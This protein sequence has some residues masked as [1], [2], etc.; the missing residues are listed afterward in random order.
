LKPAKETLPEPERLVTPA[1]L[2]QEPEQEATLRPSRLDDYVG[3]GKVVSALRIFIQAAK[4]RNE[5]LDHVLFLGPPGLGKTTLSMIMAH[6]MGVHIKVTSGPA[7]ER[8]GDLAAVLTNL[9]PYDILF[10]D[11]IHRLNRAVEEIL[12]PALEDFA[13]DI[14]IGKGPS[15]RSI[16]LELPR[17]TLIGATTRAGLITGPLRDRFGVIHRLNFYASEELQVIV[18]R[19][20]RILNL[21]LDAA[22]AFEIARRSRGTPR[23]ANRLLKRVRDFA[24]VHAQPVV[25]AKVAAAALDLMEIDQLGLDQM[26]RRLLAIVI[27]HFNGGPVGVETLAVSLGEETETLEDVYEPFL[28]QIGLLQRTPAG[29]RATAQAYAHLGRALPAGGISQ[30]S[31]L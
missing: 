15:A 11:E 4:E 10:I 5:A 8:A 28:I 20:A 19:S 31:L 18:A 16:R 12:Y 1:P 14:M 2:C 30:G 23:I 13:L 27:D 9:Q 3:Q 22:G 26:D 29:R 25:D 6:E 7:I 21:A 24:Q 17:F